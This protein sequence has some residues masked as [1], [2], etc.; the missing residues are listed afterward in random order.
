[1]QDTVPTRDFPLS[2]TGPGNYL[3]KGGTG[4]KG[5]LFLQTHQF[6]QWRVRV[7][8]MK[9]FFK[10]AESAANGISCHPTGPVP[11]EKPFHFFCPGRSPVLSCKSSLACQVS[12][13]RHNHLCD[14]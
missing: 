13:T 5:N 6:H 7:D 1:M 10:K 12:E 4:A 3:G 2:Q 8:V 11:D 14:Y 9:L